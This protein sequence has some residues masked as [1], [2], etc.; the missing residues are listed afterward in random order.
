MTQVQEHLRSDLVLSML[1][2]LQIALA[3]AI[4]R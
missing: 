1:A 3:T 4:G 2:M